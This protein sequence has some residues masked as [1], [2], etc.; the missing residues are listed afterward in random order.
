MSSI[1]FVVK[2]YAEPAG[3]LH[4]LAVDVAVFC[5]VVVQE[6]SEALFELS[7]ILEFLVSFPGDKE[8]VVL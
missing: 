4:Q 5:Q 8:V 6:T 3:L 7:P 2:V 1:G